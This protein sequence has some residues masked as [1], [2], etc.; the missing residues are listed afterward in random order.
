M[1]PP[2][3]NQEYGLVILRI[4]SINERLDDGKAGHMGGARGTRTMGEI[5]KVEGRKK[6]D[7]VFPKRPRGRVKDGGD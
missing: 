6:K 3:V 4:K 1:Q 5:Q 2:K 7:E